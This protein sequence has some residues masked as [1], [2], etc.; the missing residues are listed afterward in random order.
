LPVDQRYKVGVY[1]SGSV[2]AA[3]R[4]AGLVD[5][6][7]LGAP[8]GWRGTPESRKSGDWHLQQLLPGSSERCATFDRSIV[9]SG[10]QIDKVAFVVA[11]EDR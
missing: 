10:E 8:V 9:R 6:A 4:S 7:W 11:S 1:G 5:Y 3:L 2:I